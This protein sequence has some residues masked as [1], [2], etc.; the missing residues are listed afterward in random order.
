MWL[1]SQVRYVKFAQ[2]LSF[3][4]DGS[5]MAVAEK[6]SSGSGPISVAVYSC[7]DWEEVVRFDTRC[8]EAAGIAWDPRRGDRL[9]IWNSCIEAVLQVGDL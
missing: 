1:F 4:P 5:R 3:S 7:L 9:A 2:C 6:G 8:A